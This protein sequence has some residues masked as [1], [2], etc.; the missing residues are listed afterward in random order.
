M[1]IYINGE[2][3]C[4]GIE[5]VTIGNKIWDRETILEIKNIKVI[6]DTEIE[7]EFTD[8][9]KEELINKEMLNFIKKVEGNDNVYI[10]LNELNAGIFKGITGC[11]TFG[12]DKLSN[13]G[14]EFIKNIFEG[15]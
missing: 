11:A 3:E 2:I 12:M 8:R 9:F 10:E 13:K 15:R 7:L 14:K 5:E 6:N 1:K 4:N